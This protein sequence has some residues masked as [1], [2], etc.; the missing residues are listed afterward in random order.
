[1]RWKL[2]RRRLSIS[3]PRMIVRS[4]LPWPLRWALIAV[5][6]GFS[7]AIAMWAFEF[8]KDI[9]GLD[10]NATAELAKLRAEVAQL[11]DERE[12]M[13]AIANTA[14]S[15]LKTEK[16]AQDRLVQQMK[17]IE[18][19]N[20]ALK[21]DLGFFERLLPAGASQG[22]SIRSLQAEAKAPGKVRY[23]LLVL[24]AG[25]TL[26][27]FRGNYEVTLSGTL[28]GKPWSLAAAG[29]PKPLQMKQYLRV[30]GMIDHPVQAV[31]KNI[32]VRVMD[33]SGGV[34]ATQTAKV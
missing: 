20:L 4:H 27:E 3:A 9:A 23:Q 26:P 11:Q 19:E 22:V 28:D 25:K 21:G 15:L 2:L 6:L 31:V 10:R 13:Q 30:E 17:Q 7:A 8:G 14:D 12:R 29:G 32:Q 24:Q 18:T 34:K 16:A 33:A 1:M 5:V